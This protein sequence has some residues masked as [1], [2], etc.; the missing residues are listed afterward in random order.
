LIT[1][2]GCVAIAA[3]AAIRFYGKT[4]AAAAHCVVDE[5]EWFLKRYHPD[6]L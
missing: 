6:M 2:R 3:G 5:V 1:A 4:M